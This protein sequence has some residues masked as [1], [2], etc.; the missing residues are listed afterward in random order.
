MTEIVQGN[1]LRK[2]G[3]PLNRVYFFFAEKGVLDFWNDF[4]FYES[5]RLL[6]CSNILLIFLNF[7]SILAGKDHWTKKINKKY[8]IIENYNFFLIIFMFKLFL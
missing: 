6:K 3:K 7:S 5:D 1:W 4:N 8:R 2:E